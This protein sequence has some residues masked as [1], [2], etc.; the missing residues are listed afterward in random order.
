MS[1][2]EK[3]VTSLEDVENDEAVVAAAAGAT[4][5]GGQVGTVDEGDEAQ[6]TLHEVDVMELVKHMGLQQRYWFYCNEWKLSQLIVDD[7][8][9][10]ILEE[11]SCALRPI[12]DEEIIVKTEHET[13][14]EFWKIIDVDFGIALCQ[15]LENEEQ[16][17]EIDIRMLSLIWTCESEKP[18]AEGR[19]LAIHMY[20]FFT[21]IIHR[22]FDRFS[23]AAE[24]N[25]EPILR[26]RLNLFGLDCDDSLR[27]LHFRNDRELN[28]FNNMLYQLQQLHDVLQKISQDEEKVFDRVYNDYLESYSICKV[29]GSR[30]QKMEEELW[31]QY[32]IIKKGKSQIV[33]RR[34]GPRLNRKTVFHLVGHQITSQD[35][36][37][38]Q[39]PLSS[40][41]KTYDEES[42]GAAL[43]DC[44]E[45]D[46]IL[47]FPGVYGFDEHL[48]H[49]SVTIRGVGEKP[50]DVVIQSEE[51]EGIT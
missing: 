43:K 45:N 42:F 27:H 23:D 8:Y 31:H 16:Q 47:L 4:V 7:A 24:V 36:Q 14:V 19:A 48:F 37:Q 1:N 33:R 35:I 26:R 40:I 10:A 22:P 6:T 49:E 3:H 38:L 30:L 13:E 5:D 32:Q 2:P 50:E 11:V 21:N 17:E 46:Q 18:I 51:G 9:P 29:H 28:F 34:N 20:S 15:S 44:F 12:E 25:F 39:L 41:I